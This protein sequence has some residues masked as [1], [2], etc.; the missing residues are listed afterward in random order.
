MAY[1][2]NDYDNNNNQI[3][4]SSD[5]DSDSNA[6]FEIFLEKKEDDL[7]FLDEYVEEKSLVI[8]FED[9]DDF[10]Y[11]VGNCGNIAIETSSDSST[12]TPNRTNIVVSAAK[13]SKKRGRCSNI[14]SFDSNDV[15]AAALKAKQERLKSSTTSV[16]SSRCTKKRK[17]KRP[18]KAEM[19]RKAR[20]LE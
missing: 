20:K 10:N 14:V 11:G 4:D 9:E 8:T 15:N 7:T 5:E 16:P 17:C 2:L 1:I 3:A 13:V 6:E 12:S 19:S 18:F